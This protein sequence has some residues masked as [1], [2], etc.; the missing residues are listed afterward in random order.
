[1]ITSHNP[2][3]LELVERLNSVTSGGPVIST[4]LRWGWRIL[5]VVG[6]AA[7][8]ITPRGGFEVVVFGVLIAA[9]VMIL[10]NSNL[11]AP[12]WAVGQLEKYAA[13][14]SFVQLRKELC[15]HDP[16]LEPIFEHI[17][18]HIEQNDGRGLNEVVG[19]LQDYQR[20]LLTIEIANVQNSY[21]KS[22]IQRVLRI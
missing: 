16:S 17:H 15:A 11:S 5:G 19:I 1:M 14:E 3:H 2:N 7:L 9:W 22:W 4:V 20:S 10:V 6:V 13:G 21:H 8:M 18:S 12:L